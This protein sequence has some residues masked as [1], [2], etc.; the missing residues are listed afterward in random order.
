MLAELKIPGFS[1]YMHMMDD[2]H[3]LTIGYDADDQGSFAWFTGVM[4]QIFDVSDPKNPR[5][6]HKDVIGTR[7]SSS[8]A[9]TNHLAFNYFAPKDLL[10][11]PMTICEGSSGGG[12]YGTTMTF[13]GLM[14]FDVTAASG[15]SLRGKVR[16]PGRQRHQLQQLVDQRRVPGEAQHHHGRLRLLGLPLGDQGQQPQG[17]GPGP[18]QPLHRRLAAPRRQPNTDQQSVCARSLT[19]PSSSSAER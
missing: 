8:E 16:A 14:V 6:T 1:T 5:L 12:S 17:P 7:G 10:A 2:E 4:L 19:T 13:S 11:L 18:G 3:L 15:F 9:L